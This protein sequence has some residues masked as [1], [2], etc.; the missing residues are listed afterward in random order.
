MAKASG[1][2]TAGDPVT[3]RVDVAE[4]STGTIALTVV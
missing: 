4:V 2:A 1:R 3:V